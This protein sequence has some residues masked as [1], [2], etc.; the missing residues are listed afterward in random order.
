MHGLPL[1]FRLVRPA[2]AGAGTASPPLALTSAF[3]DTLHILFRPFDAWEWLKLTF[4]CLLLGGG[5]STAAFNW[6]LGSLSSLGSVPSFADEAQLFFASHIWLVAL[7]V[8]FVIL[9]GV[10]L[11]YVRAVFRFILVDSIVKSGVFLRKAWKENR[12]LGESYFFWLLAT[13]IVFGG[14][15]AILA[16]A[17]FPHLQL[18][19]GESAGAPVMMAVLVVAFAIL[20]IILALVITLTDDLVVPL[21]YAERA[22]LVRAWRLL[23]RRMRSDLSAL[24]IY[25]LIR[26]AVSLTVGA[27]VLF[28]LFPT[29]LAIF[30]GV[31]LLGAVAKIALGLLGLVW[32]WNSFTTFLA[33]AVLVILTALLFLLLSMAGMPEQVLIQDFGMRFLAGRFPAV[34]AL[35]P[36]KVEAGG[37]MIQ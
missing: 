34:A 19:S 37:E 30:T 31:V 20:G 27:L 10:A 9:A 6:G 23:A 13:M 24:A 16:I 25:V 35:W 18:R 21:M 8:A 29:L 1:K 15:A 28:F 26:L 3:L 5:T 22:G 11:L 2:D 14:A 7:G 4:V 17:A 12:A 36:T 32:S 33:G